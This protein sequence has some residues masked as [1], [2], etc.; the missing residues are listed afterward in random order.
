ML[1]IADQWYGSHVGRQRQG[2]EDNFFVRAP[3][4]VVADGMGGA[5]AGEVASQ[6]AVEAFEPG[7]PNGSPDQG[8]VEIIRGAN[9]RIYEQSRS[10]SQRSGMGTTCTAVYVAPNEVV[11]AHVGDSRAYLWR[12]GELTRL[13]RDHSLVGELVDRGKLTE[14]Q[15]EMHPQR[16]VITRA[17][18][19]EPDVTVDTDRIAAREGDVFLLCSDGL[20]SMIREPRIAEVLRG[21]DRLEE[22]GP[23]LIDAANEAGGRD[24]ITVVLFRLSEVD[25]PGGDQPTSEAAAV[26]DGDAG[27]DGEYD[28]FA[29]EA[30]PAPRQGVTRMSATRAEEGAPAEAA[31]RP[32]ASDSEEADYRRSA[33]VAL[34]AVAPSTP[35]P[36]ATAPQAATATATA[37]KPRRR[38]VPTFLIAGLVIF[39]IVGASAFVAVRAVF[40]L[41]LDD[42]RAVTVYRGLP[43]DLPLGMHLYSRHYTSGVTIDEVPAGRRSVF[44]DHKLRSLDDATDLVDQLETGRLSR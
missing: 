35:P 20:T 34:S 29:G 8:L 16:S 3:L 14:E 11:L 17:L 23:A 38:R 18:G 40:F 10:D 19:P 39:A 12:N 6:M 36:A 5:Q 25:A 15:A 21:T 2:N 27:G 37:K 28:T 31:A 4:Y 7:L 9:N 1:R 32:R 44:T 22:A 42:R 41:G 43:Y 30:V 24:N 13:T 26:T 33:T